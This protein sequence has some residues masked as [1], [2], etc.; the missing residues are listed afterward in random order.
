[1]DNR[2]RRFSG[3]AKMTSPFTGPIPKLLSYTSGKSHAGPYEE[4][5]QDWPAM[6]DDLAT[7]PVGPKAGECFIPAV[8]APVNGQ[9]IRKQEHFTSMH[10]LMIDFDHGTL[11]DQIKAALIRAGVTAVVTTTHSHMTDQTDVAAAIWDKWRAANPNGTPEQFLI[12]TRHAFRPAVAAGAVLVGIEDHGRE[13]KPKLV[14]VFKHQPCPKY[15]VIIPFT[16]PW[17]CPEGAT[18]A[19]AAEASA[20]LYVSMVRCLGFE[21]E[22]DL[23]IK[24]TQALV[25]F[26][27]HSEG[28]PW[29]S[30]IIEGLALDPYAFTPV[31]SVTTTPT[32]PTATPPTR[33][34]FAQIIDA[35]NRPH[36]LSGD[37]T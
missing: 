11:A 32:S 16:R 31:A 28:A 17:V 19:Q 25:Y 24:D 8:F 13:G 26:P 34:M 4:V 5:S 23:S 7:H 21:G 10:A 27:R 18:P 1:M 33:E 22:C 14:A 3:E 6:S 35:M 9:I 36:I 15:R 29:S 12:Q 37:S 30:E 2:C 20:A